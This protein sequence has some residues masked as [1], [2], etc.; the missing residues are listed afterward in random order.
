MGIV[1]PADHTP[2]LLKRGDQQDSKEQKKEAAV[3]GHPDHLL[4]DQQDLQNL[5]MA[6]DQQRH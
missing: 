5:K 2:L 1:K 6:A 4:P 3:Q